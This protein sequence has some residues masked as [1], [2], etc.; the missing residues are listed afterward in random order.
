MAI[1]N[2]DM[3]FTFACARWE[4]SAHDSVFLSALRDPHSN[5]PKPPNGNFLFIY[6][7]QIVIVY[8]IIIIHI[9]YFQENIIWWMPDTRK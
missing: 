8:Y 2:F 6:I 1:C 9:L 7:V 5:F 4:G 3:Q